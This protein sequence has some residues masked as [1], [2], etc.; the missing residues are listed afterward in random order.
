MGL[1][2]APISTAR[3]AEAGSVPTRG[4]TLSV[5]TQN[6]EEGVTPVSSSEC[7]LPFTCVWVWGLCWVGAV[8]GF[9][10]LSA[11]HSDNLMGQVCRSKH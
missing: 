7:K 4:P 11:K 10:Y 9:P 5:S 3:E 6:P 8:T 1:A 2:E